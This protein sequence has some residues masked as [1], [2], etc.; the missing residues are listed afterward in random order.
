MW[1]IIT[2]AL[3]NNRWR[4]NQLID[5][6]AGKPADVNPEHWKTLAAMRATEATHVKFEHM[7]SISKGKGSTTTHMKTIEKEVVSRLVS[8]PLRYVAPDVDVDVIQTHLCRHMSRKTSFMT[9]HACLGLHIDENA[10]SA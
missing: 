4:L 1:P 6:N 8:H 3:I 9:T 10:S 7:R 2:K 5:N